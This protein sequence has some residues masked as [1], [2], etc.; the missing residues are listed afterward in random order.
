MRT[1]D[2]Q[3]VIGLEVHVELKTATK[4]FCSCPT[5]FGAA[6]NT[7]CC[8]TCMGLPG[9]MPMLNRE[10]V[11]Q[12]VRA[13]LALGCKI[14]T[15]S[16]ADRKQYFYPDLP[17]AYQISQDAIPLCSDGGVE[18]KTEDG[19]RRIGIRRIHIEEDAGKLIHTGDRTLI[20]CNRCGVPLIEI[21]T[22]PEMH[23]PSEAGAC[24]RA[25][26][27]I[28]VACGISDCKMHEGSMRC[29]VNVSLA[30]QGE[31]HEGGVRSEIKNINSF[32]FAEK[33]IAYEIQRQSELLCRGEALQSE[34]RRYDAARGVTQ[35][36]RVK[37]SAVDYR[38]LVE[39]DLLAIHLSD[40]EIEALRDTLPELPGDRAARYIQT[41]GISASDA[42][43][44]SSDSA[45]SAYFEEAV[46]ACRYP[47]LLTNLLITELLRES[48]EEDF[49]STVASASLA[50]L[51]DLFG[52]GT[53][54]STTTKKLLARLMV[55]NFDL[56]AA[57]K[58]EGLEQLRDP[59]ALAGIIEAV[60]AENPQAVADYLRGKCAASR[61]LLGRA[62]KKT[63]GRADPILLERLLAEALERAR[64]EN[65]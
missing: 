24:L 13:G 15:H 65:V 48:G 62:M 51:A 49:C 26:R 60:L 33:A 41:Y 59:Q 35:L 31:A 47:V 40:A 2:F 21:V 5:G 36:M 54:N 9:A 39:P 57:V 11:K 34:T 23:S 17:K 55:G 63:E 14:S 46:A 16:H 3:A 4:I 8:P 53:I 52:E 28:L 1:S 7:Q 43:I 30:R 22:A 38:Y 18:I 19:L 27:D 29:D 58:T 25:L 32:A 20:D 42:A 12:A 10:V 37:E 6:P 56:R 50:T 61:A 64:K 45:L 44:L